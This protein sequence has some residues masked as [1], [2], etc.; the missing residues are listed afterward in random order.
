MVIGNSS[1]LSQSTFQGAP[2]VHARVQLLLWSVF[3]KVQADRGNPR[4]NHIGLFIG[5]L[6]GFD[7]CGQQLNGIRCLPC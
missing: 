1:C 3:V 7:L 2:R 4:N 6:V 5:I